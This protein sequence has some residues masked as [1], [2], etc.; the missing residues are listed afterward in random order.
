MSRAIGGDGIADD[1][2]AVG[3]CA[4]VDVEEW[5]KKLAPSF[6]VQIL[7]VGDRTM[8]SIDDG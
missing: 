4:D 2:N 6:D 1:K 5:V 7:E 3:Q 8:L